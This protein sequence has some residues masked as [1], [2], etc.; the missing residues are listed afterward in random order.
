MV[1]GRENNGATNWL[2]EN[3]EHVGD[4]KIL[5]CEKITLERI[6]SLALQ[7]AML[8]QTQDCS[9]MIKQTW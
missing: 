5:V 9:V 2:G 1:D 8:I 4:K 3:G 6:V 7:N